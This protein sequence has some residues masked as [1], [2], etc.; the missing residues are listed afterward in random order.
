MNEF[1]SSWRPALTQQGIIFSTAESGGDI[2]RVILEL[3]GEEGITYEHARNLLKEGR[4]YTPK[5]LEAFNYN[6][7]NVRETELGRSWFWM[8]RHEV[9][10][11][12][13][14]EHLKN[15]TKCKNGENLDSKRSVVEFNNRLEFFSAIR[16]AHERLFEMNRYALGDADIETYREQW[17][18]VEAQIMMDLQRTREFSQYQSM[19]RIYIDTIFDPTV[20]VRRVQVEGETGKLAYVVLMNKDLV[21]VYNNIVRRY[22]NPHTLY[23]PDNSNDVLQ[24]SVE[25]LCIQWNKFVKGAGKIDCPADKDSIHARTSHFCLRHGK[26]KGV[27]KGKH[28]ETQC[29]TLR[30]ALKAAPVDSAM[31]RPC[32]DVPDCTNLPSRGVIQQRIRFGYVPRFGSGM[33]YGGGRGRGRG[34]GGGRPND[35]RTPRSS[36]NKGNE[37]ESKDKK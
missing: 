18:Q 34:R 26:N 5:S 6:N 11:H 22:L 20:G 27:D 10:N 17:A 12:A 14:R 31:N 2:D 25:G 4:K 23:Q 15:A 28:R 33:P 30:D 19:V 3:A 7:R 35:R 24:L 32:P 8:A 9:S 37:K 13:A 1:P 16:G 21:N 29:Q 36:D